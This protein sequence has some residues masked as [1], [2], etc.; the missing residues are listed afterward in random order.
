MIVIIKV[1]LPCISIADPSGIES[2]F[3]SQF[4]GRNLNSP[5]GVSSDM[6][7]SYN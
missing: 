5:S 4:I 1:N 3:N 2:W 7:A 6:F